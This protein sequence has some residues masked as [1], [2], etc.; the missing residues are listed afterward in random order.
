MNARLVALPLLA[1]PGLAV[2]QEIPKP[3]PQ[4]QKLAPLIGS[5]HGTGTAQMGPGEPSKWESDHTYAWALGNFFVQEDTVV[6]FEGMPKPLVM[7]SYHGWDGEN[8][9]FVTVGADNDGSAKVNGLQFMED[10]SMVQFVESYHEG[11]TYFERYTTKVDGDSMTFAIDMIG[12][13]GPAAQAVKGTMK[14]TDKQTPAALDASAFTATAPAAIRQLGKTA[15]TY[16]VKAS[17]I[18]MPGTPPMKITGQDEVQTLFDGNIVH[19][20]T[21]GTAEGSPEQYVG[22]VFYGF[23]HRQGCISAVYVSNMGEVGEMTGHFTPDNKS[24][25]LT[26]ALQYMGQPCVQRMMMELGDDGTP[27]KAIGNTIVGTAAPYESWNATY[28]KK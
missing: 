21:T 27:T 14:R 16:S 4:L 1:L 19:V 10:G 15:G 5:W 9:R 13:V 20:H 2:A 18:M 17:M 25:I 7:R 12:L 26:S 11:Q 24:L 23:D 3:A 28:T 6:R 22:E 8:N